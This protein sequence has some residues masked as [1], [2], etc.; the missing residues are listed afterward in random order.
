MYCKVFVN[1]CVIQ[2]N[3]DAVFNKLS[4]YINEGYS[5]DSL[6]SVLHLFSENVIIENMMTRAQ[7]WR[8]FY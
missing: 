1:N 4:I 5:L 6:P 2:F 7:G 3:C 8:R